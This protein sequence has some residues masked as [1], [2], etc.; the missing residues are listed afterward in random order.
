MQH[1]PRV[2]MMKR[3]MPEGCQRKLAASDRNVL[4]APFPATQRSRR[5]SLTR[6]R[7]ARRPQ[8]CPRPSATDAI[9]LRQRMWDP[10][11]SGI[12]NAA[13]TP[14]H[15]YTRPYQGAMDRMA[16][17]T[18]HTLAV[19]ATGSHGRPPSRDRLLQAPCVGD[20]ANLQSPC[21]RYERENQSTGYTGC[22]SDGT[23]C[24]RGC[25]PRSRSTT[26]S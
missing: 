4:N 8:R 23:G 25:C 9:P 6:R 1:G 26:P 5:R 11:D 21:P 10:R 3:E 14:V 20:R 16:G 18:D 7:P 17:A 2:H 12:P 24:H 19:L 13:S 15:C 22:A